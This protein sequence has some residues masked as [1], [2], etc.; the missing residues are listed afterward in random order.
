LQEK[1]WKGGPN[2]ERTQ[3]AEFSLAVK[4]G[5][6]KVFDVSPMH[7]LLLWEVSA[8]QTSKKKKTQQHLPV[9]LN[10]MVLFRVEF[11]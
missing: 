11:S 4:C 8:L 5:M 9:G 2:L 10:F 7:P 3:G 6:L 1:Q